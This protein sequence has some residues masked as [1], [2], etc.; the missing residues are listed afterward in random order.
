MFK[1]FEPYGSVPKTK[2][3][4][5]IERGGKLIEDHRDHV[6]LEREGKFATVDQWGRVTWS[7][8]T[9]PYSTK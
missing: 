3:E 4:F 5:I 7:E 1:N 2:V 8:Q 6:V 9:K